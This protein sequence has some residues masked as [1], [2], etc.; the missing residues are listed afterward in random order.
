MMLL[1]RRA[2]SRGTPSCPQHTKASRPA[3]LT[4][5]WI[6]RH[7]VRPGAVNARMSPPPPSPERPPESSAPLAA[8]LIRA[9]AVCLAAVPFGMA[10]AHRSA[11]LVLGTGTALAL[12]A[13]YL[14]HRLGALLREASSIA[15]TPL[16]TASIAFLAFALLS[17]LWSPDQGASVHGFVEFVV[18]LAAALGL[19]LALPGRAPRFAFTLFAIMTIAACVLML[20]DL[21]TVMA[22]RRAVGTRWNS[23]IYNRPALTLLVLLPPLL[24]GLIG[25]GRR[26]LAAAAATLAALAIQ[27][28]DSGA[29]ALGLAAAAAA[30]AM[31]RLSRA[32]TLA[33]AAAGIVL[34]VALAPV[35]GELM[36]GAI[37][38]A[39]HERLK[40]SNSQA[41]VDIWR[42]FGAAVREQPWL[43]AGFAAG[44]AFPESAGARRVDPA[45]ATLLAVGH[46][47]NGALQLWTDLGAVGA[48]LA[49]VV[50][51]LTLRLVTSLPDDL[52]APGIALMAAAVAVS[53]V[54]HGLWQGWWA[55]AIGAAV[56]WFRIGLGPAGAS[57]VG[58]GKEGA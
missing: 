7:G 47:H 44:S 3:H 23:F 11:P 41:R 14:E 13:L 5:L 34:S 8:A 32:A 15:R 40:G 20:V 51:G 1:R 42:S 27:Q 35:A 56:V 38:A 46:P 33:L 39:W 9:A 22:L 6:G 52:F 50:L 28:S 58:P 37:P 16:G 45:Y 49:L 54:G 17:V 25:E 21:W 57:P 4:P 12:A 24:W 2:A 53:L 55:A 48:A 26:W 18:P 10:V 29:A 30:Y 43:G 19:G 36:Q 31:A